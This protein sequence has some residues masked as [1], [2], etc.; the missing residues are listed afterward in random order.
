MRTTWDLV[1]LEGVVPDPLPQA[2]ILAFAPTASSPLGEVTGALT[3]PSVGTPSPD[4]PLLRD[5]DLSRFHVGRAQRMVTPAW[6]RV[7]VPGPLDAPLMY[8]GTRDGQPT[9]VFAFTLEDSDLPLQVAW[10]ILLGNVTAELLGRDASAVAP[11]R[12]GSVVELPLGQG[13]TGVRVTLPD[14]SVREV[15]PSAAGSGVAT[16]VDTWQLGVYRADPVAADAATPAQPSTWFA[17]DLFEPGESSIQPG[18]G[19][20]SQRS[21]GPPGT[22]ASPGT[23]RD[24]WWVPLVLLLLV[25]LATEWLLYERDG[26]RRIAQGI[27]AP[28]G[29]SAAHHGDPA[30]IRLPFS[31]AEPWLLL[32]GMLLIATHA[33]RQ[34][35]GTPPPVGRAS[36]PE[37][38]APDGHRGRTRARGRRARLEL[39]VERLT[40]VFLV[41]LSDSVGAAG[42]EQALGYLRDGDGPAA[43]RRPGGHRR[44]R[45]GRGGGAAARGADDGGP[46]GIG[47]GALGDRR[48]RGAPPGVR[49]VP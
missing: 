23:A 21:A 4:E 20:A 5:V 45:L 30:M 24:E 47:A 43:G 12:P 34:P 1:V 44:V 2:P 26:A 41:D 17:V 33:R 42:R 14:G 27:R 8:S 7:V 46:A 36:A 6:A 9:T 40:T 25:V 28:A 37:P 18:D 38:R 32:L 19:S 10:P 3:A 11:L 31:I 35:R 15:V 48:G 39:P 49:A 16:F 13:V 22:S 29:T